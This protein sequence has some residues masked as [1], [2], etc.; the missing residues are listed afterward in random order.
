MWHR[1][2][3]GVRAP[4]P[5]V[6]RRWAGGGRTTLARNA[7]NR[8][9]TPPGSR[10]RHKSAREGA[11][12]EGDGAASPLVGPHPAPVLV[13]HPSG[14]D[15]TVEKR[16]SMTVDWPNVTMSRA[17]KPAG[18]RTPKSGS[19]GPFRA[20]TASC[21]DLN[22]GAPAAGAGAARQLPALGANGGPAP[23]RRSKATPNHRERCIRDCISPRSISPSTTAPRA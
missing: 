19:V 9:I 4:L 11:E 8:T 21:V 20:G 12:R 1:P 2:W 14:S 6:G 3:R 16:D 15:S 13:H 23:R 5:R 22:N 18:L 7:S 10:Y 17:R